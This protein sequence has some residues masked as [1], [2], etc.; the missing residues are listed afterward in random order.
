MTKTMSKQS[1]PKE[2]SKESLAKARYKAAKA[3]KRAARAASQLPNPNECVTVHPITA[4][5]TKPRRARY[6]RELKTVLPRAALSVLPPRSTLLSARLMSKGIALPP[7][8]GTLIGP[9]SMV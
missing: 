3:A 8:V 1:A 9:H 5:P 4:V 2:Q 6:V 7:K